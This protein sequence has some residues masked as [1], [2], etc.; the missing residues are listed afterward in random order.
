MKRWFNNLPL[1][2]KL[3]AMIAYA[4]A[5]VLLVSGTVW[6]CAFL[7]GVRSNFAFEFLELV[8]A[9]FVGYALAVRLQHAISRPI[10]ELIQVAYKVRESKDFSI[11]AERTTDDDFGSLIDGVND[12][13]A[14]L[15]KRDMNLRLYEKELDKRVRERTARLDAAVI[16]AQEAV[17]RAEQASRAKSDFLARMSHEIRT[18]MNG[19]LGM[20]ELLHH[21]TTLDDRQRRY[22][23]TIHQSG[24]ALLGIINDILDFS[25]IEAGK[26]ELELSLIHI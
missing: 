8:L 1:A 7:L 4:L 25:K 12:M 23:A 19:V 6:V 16:E 14:D 3:R 9:G 22:A 18:P 5:V 10:S 24:S 17:G 21:S 15:E 11:R 2:A 20:A 13:L 26:L